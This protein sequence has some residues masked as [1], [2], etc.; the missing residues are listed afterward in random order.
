MNNQNTVNG[1]INL[2]KLSD[3]EYEARYRAVQRK[4]AGVKQV[5]K[6]MNTMVRGYNDRCVEGRMKSV[7][8]GKEQREIAASN[9]A[10]DY[11]ARMDRAAELAWDCEI[12]W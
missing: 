9:A 1:N 2:N 6:E 5:T 7:K 11:V 4:W 12:E 8:K 10:D 3:I